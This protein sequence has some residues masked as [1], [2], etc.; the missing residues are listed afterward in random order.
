MGPDIDLVRNSGKHFH[1]G[2]PFETLYRA[3]A[4]QAERF[5]SRSLHQTARAPT[6]FARSA[7]DNYFALFRDVGLH[8]QKKL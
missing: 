6:A 1:A 5:I 4:F 2:F 7:I 8:R 3:T